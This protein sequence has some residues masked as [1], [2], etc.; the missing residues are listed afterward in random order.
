MEARSTRGLNASRL[1][2]LVSRDLPE[3]RAQAA[4]DPAELVGRQP[5]PQPQPLDDAGW[6]GAVPGEDYRTATARRRPQEHD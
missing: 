1:G 4:L 2:E 6:D 3:L 5:Q